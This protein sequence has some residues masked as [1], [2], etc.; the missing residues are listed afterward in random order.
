MTAPLIHFAESSSAGF[1]PMYYATVEADTDKAD[2]LRVKDLNLNTS[3][4]C[5]PG[6]DI[7]QALWGKQLYATVLFTIK[8]SATGPRTKQMPSARKTE[9]VGL[10][11][12]S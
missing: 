12:L 4:P 7:Q 9:L 11:G 2:Q 1:V 10:S 8:K 6:S 5:A 3:L